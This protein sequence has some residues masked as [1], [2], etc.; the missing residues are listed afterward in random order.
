M[1]KRLTVWVM[2][3]ALVLVQ[4]TAIAQTSHDQGV[5]AGR[6]A[7]TAIRG[8]VNQPSATGVVP[9]YTTTPPEAALAGRPVLGLRGQREARRLRGDAERSQL[10]G[11]AHGHHLGEHRPPHDLPERSGSRSRFAH[12]PQP[13][14]RSGEPGLV[15]QRLHDHRCHHRDPHRDPGLR[16]L[17]DRGQLQL[18]ELAQCRRRPVDQLLARRL[19]RAGKRRIDCRRR[20]VPAGST[21]LQPALQGHQLRHAAG[22]LRCRHDDTGHHARSGSR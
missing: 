19:V 9:G 13:L 4:T 20:A 16:P 5:A 6:A 10:P 11:A 17:R 2:T 7:N 14:A 22:V 8:M 18:L 21:G 15:L 3:Q 12:R 1:F